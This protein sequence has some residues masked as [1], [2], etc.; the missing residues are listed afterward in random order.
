MVI[1]IDK[2]LD[3]IRRAPNHVHLSG[4]LVAAICSGIPEWHIFFPLRNMILN[5]I[6]SY[7]SNYALQIWGISDIHDVAEKNCYPMSDSIAREILADI[8]N[9]QSA[10]HGITWDTL[11]NAMDTRLNSED[12]SAFTDEEMEDLKGSFILFLTTQETFDFEILEKIDLSTVL[13]KAHLWAGADKGNV[14]IYCSNEDILY[15]LDPSENAGMFEAMNE[16]RCLLNVTQKGEVY[17]W[18]K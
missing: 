15:G 12:F 17:Q 1:D 13:L 14:E 16:S 10:E 3:E 9:H 7:L 4:E 18:R 2:K 11:E 8:D 5:R 6:E